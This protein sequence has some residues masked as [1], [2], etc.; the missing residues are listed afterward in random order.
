MRLGTHFVM[1]MIIIVFSYSLSSAAPAKKT[2]HRPDFQN[3]KQWIHLKDKDKEHIH[4]VE[5]EEGNTIPWGMTISYKQRQTG[6]IGFEILVFLR[7]K[8]VVVYKQWGAP[9]ARFQAVLQRPHEEHSWTRP[10]PGDRSEFSV[11]A[12]QGRVTSFVLMVYRNSAPYPAAYFS[13]T[14][15]SEADEVPRFPSA[16]TSAREMQWL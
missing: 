16:S 6:L 3:K 11:Y 4:R 10:I 1:S 13:F 12:S 9:H 14:E 5:D 15:P 8:G 2:I 7:G